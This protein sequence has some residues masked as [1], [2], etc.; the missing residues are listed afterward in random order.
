MLRQEHWRESCLLHLFLSPGAIG[1]PGALYVR[2]GKVRAN[3]T[4]RGQSRSN[5]PA[6]FLETRMRRTRTKRS[7]LCETTALSLFADVGRSSAGARCPAN[8]CGRKVNCA[9]PRPPFSIPR[10]IVA[11][12][13]AATF[14]APNETIRCASHCLY[15]HA[16]FKVNTHGTVQV[17]AE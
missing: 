16:L 12:L 14:R 3:M 17:A 6:L 11:R 1:P 7:R 15:L 10:E 4:P 2:E 8:P 5:A 9:R 13:H